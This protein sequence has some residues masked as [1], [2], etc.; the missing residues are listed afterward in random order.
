MNNARGSV[1]RKWDLHIHAPG[2]KKSDHYVWEAGDVWQEYCRRIEESD[3]V[4]FGITDYF[5][6]DGF[7]TFI[8]KFKEQYPHSK[9]VF[10]P[11]IEL[12]TNEVVNKAREEVNSHLIF[13]PQTAPAKLSG[14]LQKLETTKTVE[15]DRSITANEIT[16]FEEASVTRDAIKRALQ[17]TFGPGV[18]MTEHVL[19]FTAANNDGIRS[20]RGVKRKALI[21][22]EYDKFSDGFFGNSGNSQHFLRK[23]RLEDSS[24]VVE[25]KPVLSCSDAHSFSDLENRLGKVVLKD[26]VRIGEP[27]WIKADVTFEGLRQIIYEPEGRVFIGEEPEVEVRVQKNK[28]RYI[29]S[30]RIDQVSGY[31]GRFGSWFKS[32]R[33]EINKELVAII[34]NKGNGKSALTD[35]IGLLGNSHNQRH[36]RGDKMEELFSFLNRDKFLKGECASHFKAEL[37]WYAGT[38]DARILD[39]QTDNNTPENVEYLPQKYLEKICANVEDDEFRHK[40]NE[41]IFEYVKKAERYE[42]TILDDLID[43][44]SRQTEA[45]I[46]AAKE[47]LREANAAVL[48]IE[49]KL[50]AD[51]KREVDEKLRLKKAE[52]EALKQTQPKQVPKPIQGEQQVAA[53]TKEI[54]ETE[55]KIKT[56]TASVSALQ[57][58]SE[59]LTRQIEELNHAKQR[60]ERYRDER[61]ELKAECQP[62]FHQVGINF[63]DVVRVVIDFSSLD[64]II[65]EKA[66]RLKEV[67]ELL[68]DEIEVATLELGPEQEKAAK[69]KS[70]VCQ[71]SVLEERKMEII[72]KLDKPNREY[73]AY[74]VAESQWKLRQEQLE[75]EKENPQPETLNGLLRELDAVAETYP[76]QLVDARK[77][78]RAG[79]KKVLSCKKQLLAFY[80]KVKKSIDDEIKK[81]GT[82]LG[83]YRISIEANLK[84]NKVFYE[85]FFS[86]VNQQ[87]KGSFHGTEDGRAALQKLLEGV[88]DWEKEDEVLDVLDHLDDCLHSDRRA[89]QPDTGQARDLFKQMRQKREALDFYDYI[90]GFD[91][92]ETKYDLKVDGKDLRELSAGERGG[93]LLTFYLMLDKRDIPLVIDQP[94]DNLDNRSVYEILVTFLKKAKKRRQ[95]IMVTHNPNLAVVAD[96]E[97]IIYV[98]IDKKGKKNDFNF[99]SGAIENPEINKL[100]VNVLE[101]TM[102]AF[103]NRR[104]KYRTRPR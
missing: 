14:F 43:Y 82:D 44:L 78:R 16:D 89:G 31:T 39:D 66:Q 90:Y 61:E 47:V 87:V 10:F 57:E 4:A 52:I 48:A 17:Q 2:T 99:K 42:Q 68:I 9:K 64:A 79:S 54:T 15:G 94:E 53:T 51:Y 65:R 72:D 36:E 45:D 27:T 3:V 85:M 55:E 23:D 60:I 88:S 102:P 5:S 97:Q 92:L 91:Y 98:T 6:I 103:Q 22:D 84:F 93:L 33:I 56:L 101:G 50:T 20:E 104:L 71:L 80:E 35:I 49:R 69:E 13:D 62:V 25:P 1:W 11:N 18:D 67:K 34:G 32:E 24:S 63:D 77:V 30:I 83:E 58:E 70:M 8:S 75:G 86:F 28:R 38:P 76:R 73:Q 12:C 29:D 37:H 41:V 40:L 46:N 81:Y 95:I 74:L 96:A 7:T 19:I 21:T 26:G 59:A 100:V